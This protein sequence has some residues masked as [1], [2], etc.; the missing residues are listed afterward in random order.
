MPTAL[1]VC[2]DP[3]HGHNSWKKMYDSSAMDGACNITVKTYGNNCDTR[4]CPGNYSDL[5][6]IQYSFVATSTVI[7]PYFQ[8]ANQWG[9]ANDFFQTNQGSS[10]AAHLFLL[11]G[12]SAPTPYQGENYDWFAAE[13]PQRPNNQDNT[14]TGCIAPAD[15]Y[16]RLIDLDGGEGSCPDPNDAHCKYPCYQHRTLIEVIKDYNQANQKNITWRYYANAAGNLWTAPTAMRDICVPNPSTHGLI[17]TGQDW[18]QNV[19]VANGLDR[20]PILTDLGANPNN[21]K[22][23]LASVSWVAPDG[24]WS[25]HPGHNQNENQGAHDGGPSFVAAIVNAVG[26]FDNAGNAL[27]TQCGYWN[28]TAILVVWDDWG[29]FYD[30]VPLP[31]IGYE[32]DNPNGQQYVYGFRVPFLVISRF[33]IPQYISPHT[34]DFGSIL[35]FI[36]YALGQDSQPMGRIGDD[37]FPYADFF[38]KDTDP[39]PQH[40]YSL[41]DFFNFNSPQPFTKILGAKYATDCFIRPLGQ[42]CFTNYVPADADNDAVDPQD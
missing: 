40:V 5:S 7:D 14:V 3:N 10:F 38:V 19:R 39:D 1:D 17:C 13:N 16:V 23:D 20:S 28:N 30:H 9:F 33:A 36:E 34:H 37:N 2:F 42:G 35:N 4:P 32:D 8:I 12:T 26:G 41:W 21:P 15:E 27:P 31:R 25:D 6:C 11:S 22:C 29:G 18:N 24:H